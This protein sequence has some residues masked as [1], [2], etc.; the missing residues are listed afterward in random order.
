M[1]ILDDV[2]MNFV[3]GL[4]ISQGFTIILVVID[5]LSE[6]THVVALK[7]YYTS[8]KVIKTFTQIVVKLHGISKSIVFDKNRVFTSHFSQRLT[9]L[10]G[11]T[12]VMRSSYHP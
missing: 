10:S 11:T 3:I 2:A 9:K 12:L 6:Y 7:S 1:Q 5:R 8:F 4:P